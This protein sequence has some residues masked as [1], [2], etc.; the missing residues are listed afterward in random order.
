MV[1]LGIDS[2]DAFA[3]HP[4]GVGKALSELIRHLMPLVSDWEVNL[5]TNRAGNIEFAAPAQTK[6]VD[7]RGDRFNAW[8]QIRLPLAALT[9][10][11]DLL[12]CPSQTAPYFAPCPV[13]LTVHD[14]IPLR[15]DDG[16]PAGEVSRFRRDLAR[17]VAKAR[18]IIAVSEFTRHDLL[19]E[20]R[21]PETK[22]DVIPWGVY[23]GR[24]ETVSD[25][26]WKIL[27]RTYDL[28]SPFFVAFGGGA[29]R[30]NVSCVLKAIALLTRAIGPDIQLVLVGVPSQG[31]SSVLA[32]S[33]TLGI[34]D[35]VIL[36]SYLPDRVLSHLLTRSEALVYPS[37]YEGFGLPILEGMAMGAP[38][39]TSNVTSMPETAGDAAVLIDPTSESEIADAM[40]ACYLNDLTKSEMRARGYRRVATFSWK[41]TAAA[42]LSTYER[43]LNAGC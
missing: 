29:P 20:F 27:C 36:L 10:R 18:R 4:R 34:A 2:R 25:D 37:L 35:N 12:H 5:F 22:I 33:N 17:S 32:L 43:A 16:W 41:K 26:E 40:R 30:K 42:T 11:L 28:R 9:S 39:I 19:S 1:R 15:M 8:E 6:W 21:V 14:L 13:V 7:I 31:K 3:E 24:H 23:V 38:V